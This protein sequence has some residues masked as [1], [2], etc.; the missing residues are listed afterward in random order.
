MYVCM[1]VCIIISLVPI[2]GSTALDILIFVPVPLPFF[3]F[4]KLITLYSFV[5]FYLDVLIIA[6]ILVFS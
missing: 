1:Y 2:F 6:T 3:G 4:R 5:L